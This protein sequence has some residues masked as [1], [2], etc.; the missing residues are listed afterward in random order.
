M[1]L[2]VGQNSSTGFISGHS[3]A[4]NSRVIWQTFTAVATGTASTIQIW[5]QAQGGAERFRLG[6][7]NASTKAAIA[8][9]AE[10]GPTTGADSWVS[11][12]LSASIVSGTSYILG[13]FAS[14]GASTSPIFYYTDSASIGSFLDDSSGAA[15][16]TQPTLNVTVNG[17]AGNIPIYIDGTVGGVTVALT[18]QRST[19][20][21]GTTAP[22]SAVALT[23]KAITSTA[24]TVV[25]GLSI[26]LLGKSG[27]FTSGLL[28][29]N[30]SVALTGQSATFSSGTITASTGGDLTLA[31]T[32]Q[33]AS[34]ATGTLTPAISIGLNGQALT[35]S[36]GTLSPVSTLALTGTA[37]T[38][39]AG[40]LIPA[41]TV[42][43]TGQGLTG[44]T[45][46]ITA[47]AGG[48]L[49]IALIGQAATFGSGNLSPSGGDSVGGFFIV[50]ARRRGAR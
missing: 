39:A 36:S 21:P 1:T 50:R 29:P 24:G 23:G 41:T 46:A 33:A 35:S 16:P 48:D 12:A 34:F 32:G 25:P 31:L 9:T 43:L 38:S 26:A 15:Y 28:V 20:T 19:F 42:S 4:T 47:S 8:Q 10:L 17:Q 30:S 18:G 2:L 27:T 22:S 5:L 49:T 14:N 44:I 11:G 7:W 45:G 40:V 37:M 6:L 13:I 3:L